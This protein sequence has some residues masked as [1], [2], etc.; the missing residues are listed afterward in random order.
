MGGGREIAFLFPLFLLGGCIGPHAIRSERIDFGKAVADTGR[1]QLLLNIIR[2]HNQEPPQFVDVSQVVNQS[3]VN[4]TVTSSFPVPSG[5]KN[6]LTP[7]FT[8]S[9]Y[10]QPSVTYTPL[11]GSALVAQIA[12]P[13][14]VDSIA[15]LFDSEWPI[16]SLLTLTAS[17]ISP[18]PTDRERVIDYIDYLA[19]YGVLTIT[20]AKSA[21]TAA[22]G[23]DDSLILYVDLT[24]QHEFLRNMPAWL[25]R[26]LS[27][28]RD[29]A[30][31]EP[32]E[33]V[34]LIDAFAAQA[35]KLQEAQRII[36]TW[37]KLRQ[38]YAG[39][40]IDPR[41]VGVFPSPH[42]G[43]PPPNAGNRDPQTYSIELRAV[44][45]TQPTLLR[46]QEVIPALR[47]RSGLGVLMTAT[48]DTQYVRFLTP[49][50]YAAHWIF[51]RAA[52]PEFVNDPSDIPVTSSEPT[53]IRTPAGNIYVSSTAGGAP[54]R[55]SF[56]GIIHSPERPKEDVYAITRY[57]T[58]YY[59]ILRSDLVSQRNFSLVGELLTMQS[60]T[61][62]AS[63]PIP[64]IT[65]GGH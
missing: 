49:R 34:Q 3:Q 60:A 54:S 38:V 53:S 40:Y 8:V 46:Q 44:A 28:W 23:P 61:A 65:V 52:N 56:I 10:D 19:R 1:E 15:A 31:R 37:K 58:E 21:Y 64:T 35:S 30:Q 25:E 4:G 2:V 26:W 32:L 13:I 39:T 27:E 20:A 51:D 45:A 33:I 6:P 18:A 17:R 12:Q 7:G 24:R 29:A 57:G 59:Y 43:S 48:S 41:T 14:T 50:E 36:A 11:L 55:R 16:G 9:S 47:M 5:S 62:T 63:A 22:G 42:A